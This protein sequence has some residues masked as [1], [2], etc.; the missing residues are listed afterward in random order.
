M[1]LTLK[2]KGSGKG[3]INSELEEQCLGN[4][5]RRARHAGL[6]NTFE[7]YLRVNTEAM[8]NSSDPA[9]RD[10]IATIERIVVQCYERDPQ[11]LR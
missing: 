5:Y 6:D 10:Y 9:I 1:Q 3:F 8:R 11:E 7:E 2:K 4:S